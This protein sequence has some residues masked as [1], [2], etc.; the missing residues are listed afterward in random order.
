MC[1]KTR[2]DRVQLQ[3][4]RTFL[5][6]NRMWIC[7]ENCINAPECE[8]CQL[9]YQ[10]SYSYICNKSATVKTFRS[11]ILGPTFLLLEDIYSE[12]KKEGNGRTM[13]I[14]LKNISL[15]SKKKLF[16]GCRL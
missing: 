2:T 7:R 14:V 12:H 3:K 8:Y 11:S 10:I 16:I 4:L 5:N 6:K 15:K 1:Y 9:I 13:K